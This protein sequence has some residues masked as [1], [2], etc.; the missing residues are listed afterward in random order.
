MLHIAPEGCF[1]SQFRTAIGAGYVTGDLSPSSA[2][3]QLD[4]TNLP[5]GDGSFDFVYCSHVLEHVFDDKAAMREFR[6]V[7]RPDGWALL[8]VPITAPLTIENPA[9][10]DLESDYGCSAK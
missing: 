6:R 5:F 1:E 3:V 9:V 7:L 4:V 8:A 10:I 2:D